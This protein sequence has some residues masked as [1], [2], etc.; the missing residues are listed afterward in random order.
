MANTDLNQDIEENLHN[1]ASL[2]KIL[3]FDK[4]IK[5]EVCWPLHCMSSCY[6]Y[7]QVK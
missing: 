2:L 6:P 5:I 4:E 1:A 7:K 3:N